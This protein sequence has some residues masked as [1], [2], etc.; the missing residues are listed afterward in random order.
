MKRKVCNPDPKEKK[1]KQK[2]E[3]IQERDL[4]EQLKEEEYEKEIH[5]IPEKE[6]ES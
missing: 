1:L 4:K 3:K 5:T 6:E 2:T